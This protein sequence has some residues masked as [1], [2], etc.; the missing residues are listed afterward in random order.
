MTINRR[1]RWVAA[2]ALMAAMPLAGTV[3]T[4][5]QQSQS[6][7]IEALETNY[8]SFWALAD[9][10]VAIVV[11]GDGDT[12]LDCSVY[13]GDGQLLA[14]DT[15][16]TDRCVMRFTTPHSGL[17]G[18]RIDNLGDVWNAYEIRVLTA[19]RPGVA[20]P[21][22]RLAFKPPPGGQQPPAL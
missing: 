11:A 8:V 20:L 6:R 12:D 10:E 1:L 13:D 14:S 4:S 7:R 3:V 18:I 21:G 2:G 16:D 15:N 17:V 9:D 22:H 19:P 5:A